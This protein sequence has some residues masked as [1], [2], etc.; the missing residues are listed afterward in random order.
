[1]LALIEIGDA[2]F[3]CCQPEADTSVN[4]TEASKVPPD[5]FGWLHYTVDTPP[6]DEAYHARPWQKPHVEN[7]TGTALAYHPPGSLAGEMR[8]PK[9]DGDYQAWNAG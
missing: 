2:K 4:V 1:M 7:M 6:K 8:R 3:A 5:W 9:S